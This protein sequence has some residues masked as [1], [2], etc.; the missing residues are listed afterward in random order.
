MPDRDQLY[1]QS[2][3]RDPRTG[4]LPAD[5]QHAA[6]PA[7]LDRMQPDPILA[8]SG[9]TRSGGASLLAVAVAVVIGFV[10]YSV[11][12]HNGSGASSAP[13]APANTLATGGNAEAPTAP[14]TVPSND[15]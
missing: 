2:P 13:P 1:Q 5:Q 9:R 8:S 4:E 7:R 6:D 12:S 15:P 10:I 14:H 11:N 3:V